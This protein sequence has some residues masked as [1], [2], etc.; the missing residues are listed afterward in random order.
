VPLRQGTIEA[1]AEPKPQG[2]RSFREDPRCHGLCERTRSGDETR[3]CICSGVRPSRLCRITTFQMILGEVGRTRICGRV[4][5]RSRLRL[6]G[7]WS[8]AEGSNLATGLL[9]ECIDE[10]L[11]GPDHWNRHP[12][13]PGTMDRA[14]HSLDD[15]RP[16][17]NPQGAGIKTRAARRL[18]C[19]VPGGAR[20]FVSG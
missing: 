6:S 2:D 16:T 20:H 13:P 15:K 7:I 17:F 1:V 9:L 3:Q 10:A 14:Q 8:S 12:A 19:V 18:V 4:E 11:F 5:G